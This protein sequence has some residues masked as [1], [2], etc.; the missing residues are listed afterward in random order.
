M[1]NNRINL[2][3]HWSKLLS[4]WTPHNLTPEINL[5]IAVLAK[6]ITEEARLAIEEYREPFTSA[7]FA[8]GFATY[9]G[10]L[11]INPQFVRR[12]IQEQTDYFAK[13]PA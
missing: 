13:E 5:L 7:F 9:C 12:A 4:R 11:G 3:L 8:S 6:A 2:E 1:S 10:V